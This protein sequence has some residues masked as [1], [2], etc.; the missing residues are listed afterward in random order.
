MKNAHHIDALNI[1]K[2]E[3]SK[4]DTPTIKKA[5][6]AIGGGHVG[7]YA[8]MARA[9]LLDIIFD[10]EGENAFESLCEEINF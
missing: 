3:A 7:E 1:I 5:I 6:R 9:A 4:Q 10:R 8:R 2:E